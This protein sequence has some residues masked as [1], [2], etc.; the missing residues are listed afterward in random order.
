[1]RDIS[2]GPAAAGDDHAGRSS[3]LIIERMAALH[4]SARATGRPVVRPHTTADAAHPGHRAAS[5]RRTAR[6]SP[7]TSSTAGAL[8]DELAPPPCARSCMRL[9]DDP[10]PLVARARDARPPRSCTA[11]S[12]STTSASIASGRMWLIDWAM[13]LVAPPAVELG[14]FLAINSRRLPRRRSTAS[15]RAMPMRPRYAAELRRQHDALTVLCGLLLRGWRKALDAAEG[16][17]TS[18]RGGAN[19]SKRRRRVLGSRAVLRVLESIP[20]RANVLQARRDEFRSRIATS[21]ERSIMPRR[22]MMRRIGS[23]IGSVTASRIWMSGLRGS[24]LNQ[25]RI[26]RREDGDG[27]QR[28]DE[29]DDLR[30]RRR[31]RCS[32]HRTTTPPVPSIARTRLRR[33][34]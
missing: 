15:W 28:E 2:D 25:L 33:H 10:S 9:F 20:S 30:G 7:A 24:R 14:W 8:F 27:Q 23:M 34:R 6:R 29:A 32:Y 16:E 12:S 1:M 22:G 18:W 31:H 5:R 3:T 11:T 13:T 17:A 4:R 26:A 21:G 19:A